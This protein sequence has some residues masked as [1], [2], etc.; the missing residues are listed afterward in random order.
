MSDSRTVTDF[1]EV[2]NKE[3]YEVLK[4]SIKNE[5]VSLDALSKIIPVVLSKLKQK[6]VSTENI[7]SNM[8][9]LITISSKYSLPLI[10]DEYRLYV[11]LLETHVTNE[12][13]CRNIMGLLYLLCADKVICISLLKNK[14]TP[15]LIDIFKTHPESEKIHEG[16]VRIFKKLTFNDKKIAG[17]Y[18]LVDLFIDFLLLI[19]NDDDLY[20]D[21]I[22]DLY[23]DLL[24]TLKHAD[25]KRRIS[26][27]IY[28]ANGAHDVSYINID[29]LLNTVGFTITGE[30]IM[31]PY[32]YISPKN[33]DLTTSFAPLKRKKHVYMTMAHSS[34]IMSDK[35]LYVPSGCVYVTFAICG[36]TTKDAFKILQGFSDSKIRRMLHDPVKYIHELTSYFGESLHIHYPEADNETSRT[37][38]DVTYTPYTGFYRGKCLAVKS[39]LYKLGTITDFTVPS[40]LATEYDKGR[41][42][43]MI[44]FDCNK[45]SYQALTYLYSKSIYPNKREIINSFK[46]RPI[47]SELLDNELKK[48]RY[49]Q[50]WAFTKFP[51]VHYN[52]VCRGHGDNKKY[53]NHTR[54]RVAESQAAASELLKK[55]TRRACKK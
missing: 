10:K 35:P 25:V 21:N 19:V 20:N 6:D 14:I 8:G 7:V 51:G 33:G 49:S 47:S 5:T 28:I 9:I 32:T 54:R 23:T 39:G 4:H 2:G 48:H 44:E 12:V 42:E 11:K 37:Y 36:Q 50:S 17:N 18:S 41:K 45:I 22:I 13:V 43:Y 34:E 53:V 52:F 31:T 15:I 26:D 30:Y 40:N 24:L 27:L 29:K 1:L 16:L 55:K 3:S 38:Y 46:G